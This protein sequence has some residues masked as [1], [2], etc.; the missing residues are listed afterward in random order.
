MIAPIGAVSGSATAGSGSADYVAHLAELRRQLA[1]LQHKLAMSNG[2][3]SVGASIVTHEVLAQQI[4]GVQTQIA[5]L[6]L[7]TAHPTA[8]STERNGHPHADPSALTYDELVGSHID[9]QV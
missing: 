6:H 5:T 9:S 8:I 4:G 7:Q 3:G 1:A 2:R